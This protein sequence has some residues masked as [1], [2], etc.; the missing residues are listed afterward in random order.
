[1]LCVDEADMTVKRKLGDVFSQLADLPWNHVVYLPAGT[2]TLDTECVV[3][4]PDLVTPDQDVP[5]Q[6]ARLGFEQGLGIDDIRSIRE[7]TRLQGR[8]TSDYAMLQ[9][10]VY[11]LQN[12]AFIEFD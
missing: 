5:A 1:M 11:Y 2:P 8:D 9:A 3:L 6:A 12:D 7:N 4:D 10:F